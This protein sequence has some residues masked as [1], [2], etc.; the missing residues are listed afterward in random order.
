MSNSLGKGVSYRGGQEVDGGLGEERG[1]GGV[2]GEYRR[3]REVRH[4]S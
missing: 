2:D 4:N 3:I 1:G